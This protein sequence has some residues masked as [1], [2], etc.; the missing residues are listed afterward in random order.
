MAQGMAGVALSR[1]HRK[2]AGGGPRARRQY[3][4]WRRRGTFSTPLGVA[5]GVIPERGVDA[6]H[7]AGHSR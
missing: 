2:C 4:P 3:G 5:Q 7:G 6:G 1:R